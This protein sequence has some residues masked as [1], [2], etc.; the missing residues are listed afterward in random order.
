M[1][2]VMYMESQADTKYIPGKW[3]EQQS[4]EVE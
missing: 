3:T 2:R 1:T 4:F